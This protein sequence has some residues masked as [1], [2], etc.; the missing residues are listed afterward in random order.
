MYLG[1]LCILL[2]VFIFYWV[3]YLYTH[4]YIMECFET[5][6]ISDSMSHSVDLPLT[7]TTSCKNFC[8]PQSRCITGQQCTSD[9]DCPGCQLNS[10]SIIGDNDAGKLTFGVTPQYSPLT[11]GYGT[12]ETQIT[13]NMYSKPSDPSFGVN[14]WFS[15]FEQEDALFNKRYKPQPMP[16]MPYMPNY[17]TKY[18]LTGEFKED[19]PFAS[20]SPEYK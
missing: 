11:S 6:L 3:D 13:N 15:N 5:P 17:P 4:H 19:G 12:Q 14:V 16:S 2:C 1:I 10:N 7:T 18:S 9:L 8:G 20:N